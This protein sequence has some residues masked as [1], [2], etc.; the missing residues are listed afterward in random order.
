M[1]A[2]AGP[3]VELK[4]M[5]VA[6]DARGQGLG[7]DLLLGIL[8][9]ARANGARGVCLETGSDAAFAA[10]RRL[11]QAQGFAECPPFGTYKVDPLSVFMCRAL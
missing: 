1:L 3:V 6:A 5:H 2:G 8:D 7:R 10:A 4:S 9:V 11:Y